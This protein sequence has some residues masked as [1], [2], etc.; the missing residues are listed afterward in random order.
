MSPGS[1]A[2]ARVTGATVV[3][4]GTSRVRRPFAD[5]RLESTS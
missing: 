5:I 2:D 1:P 3:I 4:P